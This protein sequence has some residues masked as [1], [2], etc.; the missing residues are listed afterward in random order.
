M[1]LALIFQNLW[2]SN[3]TIKN[4]PISAVTRLQYNV[5]FVYTVNG[6]LYTFYIT[7]YNIFLLMLLHLNIIPFLLINYSYLLRKLAQLHTLYV[8]MRANVIPTRNVAL[9]GISVYGNRGAARAYIL[10]YVRGIILAAISLRNHRQAIRQTS[11]YR[12]FDIC[13]AGI[14]RSSTSPSPVYRPSPN[15]YR[16]CN[17]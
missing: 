10:S 11:F 4:L 17:K 13:L 8:H 15:C 12:P 7:L 5:Y 1:A 3:N 9:H 14:G 16:Y 6:Y 2:H